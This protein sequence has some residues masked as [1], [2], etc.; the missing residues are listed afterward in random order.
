M[1][2]PQAGGV[3]LADHLP[4]GGAASFSH[5]S[6]AAA[7]QIM[8]RRPQAIH[9]HPIPRSASSYIRLIA[10]TLTPHDWRALARSQRGR[11]H[12]RSDFWVFCLRQ[13]ARRPAIQQ[14]LVISRAAGPPCPCQGT[15]SPVRSTG[16]VLMNAD[17]AVCGRFIDQVGDRGQSP[18]RQLTPTMA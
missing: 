1:R 15:V 16:L 8:P 18:P 4:G 9:Q 7:A 2:F 14:L 12:R 3:A 5:R 6:N 10:N 13:R 11:D 17:S